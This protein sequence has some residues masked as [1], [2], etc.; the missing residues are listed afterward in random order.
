M[1]SCL[2]THAMTVL[3]LLYTLITTAMV[4]IV[5][6]VA[7][8]NAIARIQIY[9]WPWIPRKVLFDCYFCTAFWLSVLFV[10]PFWIF[11]VIV[12]SVSFGLFAVPFVAGYVG[13]FFY[14]STK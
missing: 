13:Y 6:Q 9:A 10:I 2:G 1:H 8:P 12:Y 3:L 4:T 14:D 11:H 7:S 5:L